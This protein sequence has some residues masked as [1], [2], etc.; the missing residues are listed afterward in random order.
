MHKRVAK[1]GAYLLLAL[2]IISALILLLSALIL[3]IS[4]PESSLEKKAIIGVGLLTASFFILLLSVTGFEALID[5]MK[6]E[7]I[8][9]KHFPG[10][11]TGRK[12]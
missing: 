7:S 8:L 1:T 6:T 4:F 12:E 5:L 2:G 11:F 3:I 10:E 9:E